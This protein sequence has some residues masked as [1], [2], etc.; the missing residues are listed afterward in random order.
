MAPTASLGATH[1][2][3][4]DVVATEL[5]RLI[6]A[7]ELAP[8]TRLIEDRLAEQLGVSRNP[9][10]EAIRVLGAEGFVE[11]TARRGAF[12]ATMSDKQAIDLFEVRLALEP[13]AAR[14]AAHAAQPQDIDELAEILE[15]AR[16]ATDD[17][18]LDALSDLN[19]E[20]HSKVFGIGGN[21][22]LAGIG[23]PMVKRGQWLF[24]HS[25]SYRAPHSWVEH[26]GLIAAIR[27]A[28]AELAESEA[29]DHV[30]AAR[31]SYRR[32]TGGTTVGSAGG[33]AGGSDGGSDGGKA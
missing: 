27:A 19:T 6:L 11:V 20:F 16:L 18:N 26:Q 28:D 13:L 12:V 9:V 2:S 8:G 31:A 33:S 29:R 4:R 7:G 10:R 30:L 23:I 3:L 5:R 24:R 32:P 17:T 14:L 15:R 25:A 1:P 22:Y 21:D